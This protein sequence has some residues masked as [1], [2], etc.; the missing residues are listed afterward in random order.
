[1]G[2]L[3]T[4]NVRKETKSQ[5]GQFAGGRETEELTRPINFRQVSLRVMGCE[6]AVMSGV[7]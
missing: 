4:R 7:C 3:T 6:S 1:M 2:N 5:R